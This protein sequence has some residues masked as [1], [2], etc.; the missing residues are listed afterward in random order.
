[1]SEINNND[2]SLAHSMPLGAVHTNKEGRTR[3]ADDCSLLGPVIHYVCCD[4]NDVGIARNGS[5]QCQTDIAHRLL[6]LRA[7]VS[8]ADQF[9]TP[10]DG[11]L[12]RRRMVRPRSKRLPENPTHK[13]TT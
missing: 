2:L 6:G 12:T 11:N 10:V 9:A 1:L 3:F 5:G 8:A 13:R 7:K 4:L